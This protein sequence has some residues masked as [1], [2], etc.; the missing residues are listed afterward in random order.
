VSDPEG[1]FTVSRRWS[2][3]LTLF[4]LVLALGAGW[5]LLEVASTEG[6]SRI[7]ST[8]AAWAPWLALWRVGL[9]AAI[10]FFWSPILRA[11]IRAGRIETKRYAALKALRWRVVG[12]LIVLELVLVRGVLMDF[13]STLARL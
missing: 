6:L 10:A 7:E 9:I 5:H 4:F 2:V 3:A 8:W 12:W 13:L 1:D 11:L